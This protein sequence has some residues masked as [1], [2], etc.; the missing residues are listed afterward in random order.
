MEDKI[1][2]LWSKGFDV[3]GD[4]DYVYIRRP[5]Y[6]E[7]ARLPEM[8][9]LEDFEQ[10]L[11]EKDLKE[12]RADALERAIFDGVPFDT[13]YEEEVLDACWNQLKEEIDE[14]VETWEDTETVVRQIDGYEVSLYTLISESD[15]YITY[16]IEMELPR[17]L[18][19]KMSADEIMD[20]F[21]EMLEE[22]DYPDLGIAEII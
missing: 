16:W 19:E 4:S 1:D 20:L 14:R 12:I 10:W 6:G 7:E 9:D 15:G 3:K 18:Y 13:A 11:S 17:E 2:K 22:M 8:C 21:D 5:I